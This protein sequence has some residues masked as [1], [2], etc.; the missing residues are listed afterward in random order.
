M[1]PRPADSG[2][3]SADADT[4]RVAAEFRSAW[5]GDGD[6]ATASVE[7]LPVRLAKACVAVLPV[8]A[9]GLS[10]HQTDF[11]LPIGASDDVASLAERLQFTQGEGPCLESTHTRRSVTVDAAEMEERW[12]SFADELFRHTPYRT[13]VSLPVAITPRAFAALDLYLVDAAAVSALSLA[14]VTAVTVQVAE[15]L[16]AA[17]GTSS[18]M[19][20]S[21]EDDENEYAMPIWL[22]V[23]P[24][25]DRTYVWVAMGMVMAQFELSAGDALALLR[26]FAYGHDRLL[27]DVAI[28]LVKGT[29]DIAQLQR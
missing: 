13:I 26:S 19:L 1:E 15:A 10:L 14:S 23:E 28:G 4:A 5:S 3:R 17:V 12:P 29:L 25:R 7:L 27:D 21:D 9:A 20:S 16:A 22:D 18:V 8:D 2:R 11:R 24:A 6:P